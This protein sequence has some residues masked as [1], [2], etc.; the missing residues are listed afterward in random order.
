MKMSSLS[1]RKLSTVT[2]TKRMQFGRIIA[3]IC[4]DGRQQCQ[5]FEKWEASSPTVCKEPLLLTL[6]FDA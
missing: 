2:F 1:K 6:V 3:R 5:T 4:A